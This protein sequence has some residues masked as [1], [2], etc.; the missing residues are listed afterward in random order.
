MRTLSAFRR[1]LRHPTLIIIFLIAA[2]VGFA[3]AHAG[4]AKYSGIVIDAKNGQTLY[5][6]KADKLRYP[7]SLTKMM[8]LYMM[9]EAFSDGKLKKST[10]IR[11][12]KYAASK[13]PSKLGIKPGRS[14]SAEQAVYALVTKSAND[15]AAAVAEHLGGSESGF[16]VMMTRKARQLGMNSTTYKNASGLTAKGQLTT[17]RDQARLGIALREHF[18]G[19][20]KYFSTR[21]FT[22]GKRRYGNHNRL[23]G[24]IKGVDGIKTGYTRASGYNLVSSVSSGS[25]SIVAV[26]MG[27]RSGKSRN[28][29][30]AKLIKSYLRKA[31]RGS[32]KQLIASRKSSILLASLELPKVGPVPVFRDRGNPVAINRINTAHSVQVASASGLSTTAYA[33]EEGFDASA[34]ESHLQSLSQNQTPVP[35][36]RPSKPVSGADP[37]VTASIPA[38]EVPS[39]WQVQIGAAESKAQALKLLKNAAQKAPEIVGGR[40]IYTETVAKGSATLHR[41][42]FIGFASKQEARSICKALKRKKFD[43]LALRG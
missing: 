29:Q 40:Q 13:P 6:Y 15:V 34:V 42:R 31:T 22:Y 28:A 26:V 10:R 12:S 5:S 19:Y 43:C 35:A 17:A 36:V 1:G 39:G 23:L 41:A 24:R 20:Y 38:A 2:I 3:P 18:P 33:S 16:A 25:R 14:L 32:K 37:V 7:A 9:F 27:G 11:M 8:T 21:S 30:M 4:N